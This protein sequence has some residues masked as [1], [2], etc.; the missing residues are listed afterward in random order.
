M[1]FLDCLFVAFKGVIYAVVGS[2]RSTFSCA[3]EYAMKWR[4]ETWSAWFCS[5]VKSVFKSF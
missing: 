1:L 5:S 2:T 3:L 4:M